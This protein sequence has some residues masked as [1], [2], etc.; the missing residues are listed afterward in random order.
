MGTIQSE[1]LV[2][3]WH[4]GSPHCASQPETYQV[5]SLSYLPDKA[6]GLCHTQTHVQ[7]P[8]LLPLTQALIKIQGDNA[9][10]VQAINHISMYVSGG[11]GKE[12]GKSKKGQTESSASPLGDLGGVWSRSE[13]ARNFF[14][15]SVVLIWLCYRASLGDWAENR[16]L[17]TAGAVLVS[18]Y[19]LVSVGKPRV[20]IKMKMKLF[21][22]GT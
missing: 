10:E 4:L 5:A 21:L 19:N 16:S 3:P 2:T 9:I 18:I 15:W 7:S 22:G 12:G 6:A 1:L 14:F 17:C 8:F 20:F 11:R 13:I